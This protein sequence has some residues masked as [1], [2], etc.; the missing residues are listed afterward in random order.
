MTITITKGQAPDTKATAQKLAN[1][2]TC[3]ACEKEF[4]PS[5]AVMKDDGEMECPQSGA[6]VTAEGNPVKDTKEEEKSAGPLDVKRFEASA[7]LSDADVTTTSRPIKDDKGQ[8]IDYQDVRIKGYLTTWQHVTPKD[9][10]GEYVIKGAFKN[11]LDKFMENSVMLRDHKNVT[12]NV[13]GS[14]NVMREDDRGL[15]FEATLGNKPG[16]KDTRFDVVEGHLKTVSMGGV[17]SYVPSGKGIKDVV[18]FEG[19]LTP[20]PANPDAR[21]SVFDV[22]PKGKAWLAGGGTLAGLKAFEM[23]DKSNPNVGQ[24]ARD[25]LAKFTCKQRESK[26]CHEMSTKAIKRTMAMIH[27]DWDEEEENGDDAA[28]DAHDQAAQMH[29]KA[30]RWHRAEGDTFAGMAHDAAAK[31]HMDYKMLHMGRRGR[32]KA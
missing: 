2:A 8:I 7:S 32:P 26:R 16:M 11:S 15:Y 31:W 3:K 30:G 28:V 21:F 19:T 1:M 24:Q 10:D 12:E 5:K 20:I 23:G 6:L 22:T 4:D 9:R 25:E 13:A 17:F 27:G 18:L 29:A 14:F